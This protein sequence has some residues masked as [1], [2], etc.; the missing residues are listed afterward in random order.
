MDRQSF[1]KIVG[2]VITWFDAPAFFAWGFVKSCVYKK[3][4]SDIQE[5]RTRIYDA[6]D[7]MAEDILQQILWFVD[8][9]PC[10]IS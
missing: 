1:I 8:R 4:S 2:T 9:A 3:K 6:T 7:R 10:I 5:L